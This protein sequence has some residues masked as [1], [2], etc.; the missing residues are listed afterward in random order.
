MSDAE[1]PS[2]SGAAP[3]PPQKQKPRIWLWVS[4]TL[5]VIL[6]AL[7]IGG[8]LRGHKVREHVRQ[9]MSPPGY[10]EPMGPD[11]RVGPGA[12]Q[13]LVGER[14][15]RWMKDL[16]PETRQKVRRQLLDGAKRAKPLLDEAR[17]ARK[18]ATALVR[19]GDGSPE[20][21]DAAFAKVRAADSAVQAHMQKTTLSV[22]VDLPPEVRE[23][24]VE[25]LFEAWSM[26]GGRGPNR[27]DEGPERPE[28]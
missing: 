13:G 25:G 11:Q 17:A 3:R 2:S 24:A 16:P 6:I 12:R 15:A 4:V 22:L 18:E 14:F 26:R 8:L 9:A 19:R 7:L 5:N 10:S 27:G 28:R 23:R 21:L 1:T 20:A